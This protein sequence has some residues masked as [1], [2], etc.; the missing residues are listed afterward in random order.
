MSKFEFEDLSGIP[1]AYAL[2]ASDG[3][4][5][6]GYPEGPFAFLH[7]SAKSLNLVSEGMKD[8]RLWEEADVESSVML[9][10]Q[11]RDAAF[12]VQNNRVTCV[13]GEISA[14]GNS[15]PEAATRA[16]LAS[17]AAAA[18]SDARA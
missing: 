15:Y 4:P 9:L 18:Q 7:P 11:E 13:I 6:F 5:M 1:L 2:F 8:V 10:A 14:T 12:L 17:N 16:L 3:S